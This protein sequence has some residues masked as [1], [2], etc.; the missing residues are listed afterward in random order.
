MR[1]ATTP[2]HLWTLIL[3]TGNSVLTINMFL[4]SLPH[5]A[6]DFGVSYAVMSLSVGAFLLMTTVTQLLIGPLSDRYGRRPVILIGMAIYAVASVICAMTHD[7]TVFLIARMFQSASS[8]GTALSRAV[9]RDMYDDREAASK[10]ATVAMIMAVAPMLGPSIG[11]F[12]DTAFGWRS[13]FVLY[14]LAGLA[15]F[16]ISWADLG[17][18]HHDRST[19]FGAQFREYPILFAS[20]RFWGY[21]FCVAFSV[22]TFHI[23]VSGAPLV[24]AAAFG[25]GPAELGLYMGTITLG[26]I[27]GSAISSRISRRFALA[28]MMIAGR[29]IAA[30][31]LGAAALVIMMGHLSVPLFFGA[32]VIS[33]IGNGLTAPS[34]NAGTMSIRPQVA[35]SASGLSSA[36]VVLVGAFTTTITGYAVT[37]ANGAAML[38]VLMA[39][40][41]V[42]GLGAALSVRYFD[43]QE[44]LGLRPNPNTML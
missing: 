1:A 6:R 41:S 18:T 17:E 36:L 37:E 13:I 5:M 15:L 3:L 39:V 21:A 27:I 11:G 28:T 43:R 31:G 19:T 14:A 33:G 9:V 44:A 34:A 12:I 25:M 40:A 26:F 24:V 4:P 16:V 35:G 29:S 8:T 30:V 2:P 42:I 20:R 22:S 7:I 23:F 32:M 10:M 38:P